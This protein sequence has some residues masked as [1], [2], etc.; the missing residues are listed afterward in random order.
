MPEVILGSIILVV[1]TIIYIRCLFSKNNEEI[2][3]NET[4]TSINEIP[5]SYEQTQET[6]PPIYHE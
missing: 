1:G 2:I 4:N 6:A 3:M 5:P